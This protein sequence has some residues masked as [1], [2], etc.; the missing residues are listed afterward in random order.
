M[1]KWAGI[2]LLVMI[3]A[4]VIGLLIEAVRIIAWALFVICLVGFFLTGGWKYLARGR[5][6]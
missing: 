6:R 5:D 2:F 3:A 4:A 1:L